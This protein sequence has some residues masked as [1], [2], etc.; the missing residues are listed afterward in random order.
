MTSE[1]MKKYFENIENSLK[2]AYE[3]ATKAREKGYDPSKK[4]SILLTKNM[5]ER[6]VGLISVVAPQVMN[7]GIPERIRYPVAHDA[8]P[9]PL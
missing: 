7:A 5:A 9:L 3:I 1:H 2:Q 8:W 6:V 4:V